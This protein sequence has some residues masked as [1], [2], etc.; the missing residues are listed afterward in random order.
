MNLEFNSKVINKNN[1]IKLEEIGKGAEAKIYK[2]FLKN[3]WKYYALREVSQSL[4]EIDFMEISR[5]TR[6]I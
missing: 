5:E 4:G 2:C 3:D 1:L 6:I